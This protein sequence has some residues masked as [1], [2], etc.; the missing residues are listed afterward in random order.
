MKN[1]EGIDL[2]ADIHR[3]HKHLSYLYID[4]QHGTRIPL[5]KRSIHII[6]FPTKVDIHFRL[7]FFKII[8]KIVIKFLYPRAY[9][10]YLC[11]SEFTADYLR[12]YW[13]AIAGKKIKVLYPPVK[14][15]NCVPVNK[16]RKSQILIFSRISSEKKIDALI[17]IF[18]NYYSG[19]NVKLLIVGAVNG[20]VSE[21][22]YNYLRSISARN[23]EF[24]IN[25]QREDIQ[26]ILDE[27]MIF[28]HAMGYFESEPLKF[29]H[30]GITTVQAMSAG[31]IP[32]VINK[33]GQ[34]EIV[35]HNVN[36]F[37]WDTP[38]ELF[39]YTERILNSSPEFRE[40][41]SANAVRKSQKYSEEEF[42]ANFSNI[43]SEMSVQL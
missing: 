21:E 24:V 28:W 3:G 22:Y 13:P 27:S 40:T 20:V 8:K 26:K 18:N 25:L 43:L 42:A 11:N 41:L 14:L 31:V 4:C 15:F 38:M 7:N 12:Q 2:Y 17:A 34:R 33:G 32:V 6:H 5:K 39:E 35:D 29:E 30:F 37:R 36:G 16:S 23:V 19:T 9:A 10:F 1:Y